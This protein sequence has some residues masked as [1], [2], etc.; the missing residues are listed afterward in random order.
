MCPMAD[1]D[2]RAGGR[3]GGRPAI[4]SWPPLQHIIVHPICATP[5]AAGRNRERAHIM[6]GVAPRVMQW[7]KS[8]GREEIVPCLSLP[9]L[10]VPFLPCQAGR[11]AGS[12]HSRPAAASKPVTKAII[13]IMN[14]PPSAMPPP[15]PS[16]S[17]LLPSSSSSAL[18]HSLLPSLPSL[19]SSLRRRRV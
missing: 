18:Q 16:S 14:L 12:R 7:Q 11:Q 19:S 6:G 15:R 10:L 17:P 8:G 4:L 1:M 5:G 2:E 9:S 13:M 3:A